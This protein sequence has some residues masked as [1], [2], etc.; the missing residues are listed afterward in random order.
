MQ[1]IDV[2]RP[3]EHANG[4]AAGTINVPLDQLAREVDRFDPD[5]PT[6]VICQTG[7]RSSIGTSILE[8]AGIRRVFNVAG[9][10]TAWDEAGLNTEVSEAA[11]ANT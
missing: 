2:R 10:T 4:H 6:Y 5:L 1:F 3:Q 8:N 7:Y 9:G 11:C